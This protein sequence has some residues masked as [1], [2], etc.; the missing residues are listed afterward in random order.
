M[1]ENQAEQF[2]ELPAPASVKLIDFEEA[3]V[4]P[5][6]VPNTFILIVSGTKPYLNMKVELSPLVYIRQP[7][8]WGI[9]VVGSLPGVG[10]PAT[11]PYTV[12]L[13]LDGIIGTKGIEVIGA[14]TRKTFEV[15]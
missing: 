11:A 10:L 15:P 12:S 4:V 6:I 5:G 2:A 9:E 8:F 14:N 7:E 13:P 3:R 1:S